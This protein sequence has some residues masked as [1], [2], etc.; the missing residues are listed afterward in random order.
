MGYTPVTD[1]LH[2]RYSPVRRSSAMYCYT[3]LPLDLHVLSLSLA[4]ILSQDQT[5]HSIKNFIICFLMPSHSSSDLSSK[6]SHLLFCHFNMFKNSLF[7]VSTPLLYGAK[8]TAKIA[9]LLLPSK[10]F[11]NFF[12]HFFRLTEH[13]AMQKNQKTPPPTTPASG[14]SALFQK[15][16]NSDLSPQ[17]GCKDNAINTT[18]PNFYA[19]FLYF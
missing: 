1:R 4:F 13:S 3:L 15:R 8:V 12:Q 6:D 2:T 5:L 9:Q 17:S 7:N 19:A 18:T 14:K 11:P 10:S 16:K